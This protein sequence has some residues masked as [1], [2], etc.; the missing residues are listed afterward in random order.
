MTA[1]QAFD[2]D[3]DLQQLRALR[4]NRFWTNHILP[5]LRRMKA[6]HRA[7][8]RDRTRPAADRCEHITAHDNAET[9]LEFLDVREQEIRRDL[10]EH[11][12]GTATIERPFRSLPT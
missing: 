7:A 6:E 3:Q 12:L 1:E 11:D 4:E 10:H 8:M 5:E 9:M 2:L